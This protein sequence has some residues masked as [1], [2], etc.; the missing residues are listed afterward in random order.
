LCVS[1]ARSVI[2]FYIGDG[3]GKTTAAIGLAIR[4]LGAGKRVGFV[5]FDKGHDPGAEDYS[6]R[7]VLRSLDRF[8]L[9]ATGCQRRRS[10][11]GFRTTNTPE[12]R[13]EARR[14]LAAVERLL[15]TG[16]HDLIVCD[17]ILTCITTGLIEA[18]DVARILDLYA[19]RADVELVM[20]GRC[21]DE[22]LIA[23]ADL[24]TDMRKVKHYFDAGTKARKGFEF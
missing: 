11:G 13:A 15:E 4:A 23:R 16:E 3:K 14:G 9:I 12:D 21:T 24:V 5:Q 18:G 7:R 8:E 22:A 6:E 17:E 10:N 19:G 1:E 20:T 2:Q